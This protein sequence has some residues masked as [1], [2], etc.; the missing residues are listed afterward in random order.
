MFFFVAFVAY[1]A[2]VTFVAFV[3]FVAFVCR[4]PLSAI[5]RPDHGSRMT[6]NG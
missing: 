4:D 5:D 3:A 2:F 1:V 6:D